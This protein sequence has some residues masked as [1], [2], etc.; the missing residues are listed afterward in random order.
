MRGNSFP[1]HSYSK[2]SWI[3]H[4]KKELN[5]LHCVWS[6]PIAKKEAK[7]FC[8]YVLKEKIDLI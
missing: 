2:T 3:L 6:A 4:G 7:V 1:Y 8:V 5:N